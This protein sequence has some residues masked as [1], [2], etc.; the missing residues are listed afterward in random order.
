MATKEGDNFDPFGGSGT[1]Y[2]I[3]EIKKS[4]MDWL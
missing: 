3:V 2:V 4:Q 1:T